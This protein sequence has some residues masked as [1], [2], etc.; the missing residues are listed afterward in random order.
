MKEVFQQLIQALSAGEDAVLVSVQSSSGSA[1]RG[2]GACMAVTK[3]GR[4]AGTIGGGEVEHRGEQTAQEVLQSGVSRE[5]TFLLRPNSGQDLGMICGGEIQVRFR[6]LAGGDSTAAAWVEREQA[7]LFPAGRVYIFGGGHVSQALVPA[8]TAVE[9][10]C[11]VL[12]DR[13]EF[14]RSELFPGVEEVLLIDNSRVAD[15][16]EL[17]KEDWVVIMTRGHKDDLLIQSQV[18]KAPVRY[19]GVIGSRQKT[20]AVTAKLRD[21]GFSN[22]DFQKVWAPIGLPIRSE[23]PAEIAVSIAAQLILERAGGLSKG[24]T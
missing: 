6:Y 7:R 19:I 24:V 13:A 5:E 10:R 16:V 9:F 15:F 17:T 20:A 11:V 8:L 14:C 12:E 3:K 2:A 1:P 23:T 22:A 21:M 4:I 18:M